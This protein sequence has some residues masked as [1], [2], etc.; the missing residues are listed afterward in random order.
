MFAHAAPGQHGPVAEAEQRAFLICQ[1]FNTPWDVLDI[2][3]RPRIYV[4][5]SRCTTQF[6]PSSV[7]SAGGILCTQRAKTWVAVVSVPAGIPAPAVPKVTATCPTTQGQVHLTPNF[8]SAVQGINGDFSTPGAED[9][10]SSAC[11]HLDDG[12]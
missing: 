10:L 12:A 1:V 6:R 5:G 7:P 3:G 4:L 9:K 8:G 11:S 2:E